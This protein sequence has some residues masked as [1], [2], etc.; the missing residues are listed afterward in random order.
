VERGSGVSQTQAA[1]IASEYSTKIYPKMINAFS[2]QVNVPGVGTFPDAMAIA[3]AIVESEIDKS[4]TKKLTILVLD[5]KDGWKKDGDPYLAGYFVPRDFL[6]NTYVMG[7]DQD[8]RSN[9]RPMIYMDTHPALSKGITDEFYSTIAHE[10]QHLMNLAVN[11]IT[12]DKLVDLWINEGLSAAAEW[13]YSGEY[14]E[15]RITWFN[16]DPTQLIRRGNNF[17]VWGNRANASIDPD[18]KGSEILDDYATVYLFFQWLRLKS[19]G[20]GPEV[21]KKINYSVYYDYNAVVDAMSGYSNWPSLLEGWFKANVY[22]DY[23]SGLNSK[24]DGVFTAPA[25][26]SINLYPGEGVYS[27]A[28]SYTVPSSTTYINYVGLQQSGATTSGS[29]SGLL[30][31]Y[32][33]NTNIEGSTAIGTT[34]G[35]AAN[36]ISSGKLPDSLRKSY[37]ISRGDMIRL[38]GRN[39][40][41]FDL[42]V[43]NSSKLFKGVLIE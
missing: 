19:G 15:D 30:L 42:T 14:N 13:V 25:Q 21:Y 24:I 5:I 8:L 41:I 2:Q 12:K 1:A 11:M 29:F 23:D 6:S 34:T 37:A 22:G 4:I 7:E 10:M 31:T 9:E 40:K 18:F 36:I 35:V 32:N 28:N 39:E 33:K 20:G 27:V 43:I 38:K 3:Y 26:T 16:Y 17:F